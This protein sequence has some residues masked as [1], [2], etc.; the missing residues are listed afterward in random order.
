VGTGRGGGDRCLI[1]EFLIFVIV[2]EKIS[3][4]SVS[5][6]W[7]DWFGHVRLVIVV[8]RF[9]ILL[10]EEIRKGVGSEVVCACVIHLRE[11]GKRS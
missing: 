11:G 6:F 4:R 10:F 9:Q 3:R 2:G 5:D 8:M 7:V 1:A